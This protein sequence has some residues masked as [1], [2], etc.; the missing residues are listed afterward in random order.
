M[1]VRRSGIKS[2]PADAVR[3]YGDNAARHIP[4]TLLLAL[5]LLHSSSNAAAVLLNPAY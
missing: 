1:P 2:R 5:A 4:G 3:Y